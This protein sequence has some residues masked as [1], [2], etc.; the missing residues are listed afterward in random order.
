MRLRR[1]VLDIL[2]KSE[3]LKFVDGVYFSDAPSSEVSFPSQGHRQCFQF[4]DESF[5]FSHR[6][7]CITALVKKYAP[8]GPIFD[9]GGG[10]GFVSLGLQKDGYDVVLI[11]PG[12]EGIENAKSR[13]VRNLVCATLQD[14]GF[15]ERSI[16]AI[17][18]FDVV[19]HIRDDARFVKDIYRSLHSGGYFYLTVPAYP[20]LWSADDELAG[21]YRR[22]DRNRI[23][24]L[25]E[26]SGFEIVYAS[27]FFW[28][29]PLLIFIFRSIP[30]RLGFVRKSIDSK[31]QQR[32]HGGSFSTFLKRL[33]QIFLRGEL[34]SIRKGVI[35]P[36][37][38][39]ILVCG[40]KN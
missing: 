5:W 27:Y 26:T 36:F 15:P 24:S 32:E 20:F 30:S 31:V 4:E 12:R 2:S 22:Y 29:L 37:G 34:A 10:N 38:G 16:P 11:E 35:M 25:L 28:F 13:G 23:C 39:S 8:E 9:V 7:R 40:R 14:A 3:K 21:H 17:G 33:I 18:A 1:D 19:E 6:N